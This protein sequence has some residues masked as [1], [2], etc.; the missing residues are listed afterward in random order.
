MTDTDTVS[1]L[2]TRTVKEFYE[3]C[4]ECGKEISGATEKRVEGLMSQHRLQV[5]GTKGA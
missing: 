1:D 5:H 3:K 4:P 2:K